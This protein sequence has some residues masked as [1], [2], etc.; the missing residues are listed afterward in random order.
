LIGIG[1]GGE[2]DRSVFIVGKVDGRKIQS[3]ISQSTEPAGLGFNE[4]FAEY[5]IT[6]FGAGI[7]IE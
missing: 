3:Q 6:E 1:I 2:T 4:E 5:P 7:K